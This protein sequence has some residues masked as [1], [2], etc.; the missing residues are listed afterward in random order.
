MPDTVAVLSD[1]HGVLPALDAVLAEPDVRDADVVVLPGDIAT[2]PQPVP[3][4]DLLMSMGERVRWVSGN[5]ERVLVEH[6][7]GHGPEESQ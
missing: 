6:A 3:T 2:G 4:L 7:R 1:I 5:C